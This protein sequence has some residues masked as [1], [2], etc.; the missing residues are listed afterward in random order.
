MTISQIRIIFTPFLLLIT[1]LSLLY[2]Q[3]I[4]KIPKKEAKVTFIYIM[5]GI[6]ASM[7][8]QISVS[9]VKTMILL[10]MT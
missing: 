5:A 9:V 7:V 2:S 1:S 4:I 3:E 6:Q 8:I 10:Y